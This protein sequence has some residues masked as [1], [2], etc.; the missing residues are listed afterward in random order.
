MKNSAINSA[1]NFVN[2]SIYSLL[3]VFLFAVSTVTY[4]NQVKYNQE[5]LNEIGSML[6]KLYDD[7]L[8]PN[9]VV[10]IRRGDE[11]IYFGARG[12]TELGGDIPV[13]EDSIYVLASMS[14]PIVST[15]VL[16][17][18]EDGVLD[19]DDPL[20][21]YFPQFE[22]MLVAPG[23]DLDVPFE[24]ANKAITIRHL[25]T[26]TSGF[27][28]PP[29]VLG[30]GDVAEQYDEIGLLW[31]AA[32]DLTEFVDIL[33]Q[34]PLVAHPGETFNYSVS[35]SVLGAVIEKVTNQRLS[36]Y[37]RENI[38]EPLGMSNTD[39]FVPEEKRK[40]L[41]RMYGPATPNN[42]AP[43]FGEQGIKW[44][45][46]EAPYFGQTY[47]QIGRPPLWDMGGGGLFSSSRDFLRY[48]QMV[49]NN[50]QLDGV[51]ILSSEMASLHFEDL[52]PNLG[53][54]AFRANFGDAASFMQFG[55]GLGIK[56]E[57][58][59]SGRHDYYFWGGAANTFFWIDGE[60]KSVGAFF[61]HMA[62]PR[63]NLTDQI[64]AIVDRARI[65]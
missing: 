29:Q 9:Y 24:E 54:E 49:A 34:I 12:A 22:S 51:R 6:N 45:I 15:A 59:G 47:D 65:R 4:G 16:M 56:M 20:S 18:I 39:F 64:E 48:S 52:M 17:L 8:I 28:Y 63:Y 41:P 5:T 40:L 25:I 14:K 55:G 10:D 57:E 60:D 58:D 3:I 23:G 19:L 61:T 32:A 46:S 50:G 62:P 44:Q 2:S 26:H 7:G 43:S 37:L 1:K 33:S 11:I 30:V 38:F 31:G 36:G 21:K 27:T 42:P 53:L 13:T 35:I